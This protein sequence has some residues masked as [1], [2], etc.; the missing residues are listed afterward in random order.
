MSAV[1]KQEMNLWSN[2]QEE[3]WQAVV[4][5]DARFD[6]QFVFAVSSTGIY[7]R[8]SCPS[9]R[10]HRERVSF[11]SLPEAAERAAFRACLRC[12]PRLAKFPDPQ[13]EMVR[14]V[15]RLIDEN[16]GEPLTLANLSSRVGVSSFHLQRTFKSVMGIS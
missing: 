6:G 9:R 14:E 15:C 5:K 12:H 7:C 11:F 10:P 1:M 4:S 2:N 3:L 16:D 8:P 13:I